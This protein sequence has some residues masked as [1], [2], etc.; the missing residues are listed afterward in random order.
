MKFNIAPSD[1][2]DYLEETMRVLEEKKD[3]VTDLDSQL[4]DG[5]HWVNLHSGFEKVLNQSE[6][7]RASLLPDMLKKIG[8]T[9]LSGVGGSSG[10][11]YGSAYI[12]IANALS[13]S[14]SINQDNFEVFIETMILEIQKRG[15]VRPGDK[16]MLD[17]LYEA[18]LEYKKSDGGLKKKIEAFK[19]GAQNGMLS[20]KDMIAQKGRG[21]YHAKKG[22]GIVDAG[23]VTMTI[24]MECLAN[25]ILSKIEREN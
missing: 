16:T 10:L 25:Y 3:E 14:D 6:M 7:L 4:G 21:R 1:Y 5:D 15:Q 22:V 18:M 13:S 17:S 8:M 23:A 2:M 19:Q 11:L 20:T 12:A 9:L 24:Q